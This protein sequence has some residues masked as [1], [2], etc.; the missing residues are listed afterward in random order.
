MTHKL[1]GRVFGYLEVIRKVEN[2]FDGKNQWLCKCECGQ[3]KVYITN[4]LT[5]SKGA[6]TCGAC[7]DHIKRKDAYISWQGAKQRC[8][9][10]GCKD[11]PRYGGAGITFSTEWDDF[12]AFYKEMGDP[13]WDDLYKERYSLERIDNSRG[14]EPGNCKWATRMEQ[15]SNKDNLTFL[16]W[17]GYKQIKY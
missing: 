13:P 5:G 12:K 9:D 8:R 11:Y 2:R 7:Q 15:A 1:E 16:G 10:K 4:M 14:Y 3:H 17:T 6:K